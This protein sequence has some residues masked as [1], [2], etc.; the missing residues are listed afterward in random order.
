M[1]TPEPTRGDGH[2]DSGRDDGL[3]AGAGPGGGL[4][5]GPDSGDRRRPGAHLPGRVLALV[6]IAVALGAIGVFT[7]F[8]AFLGSAATASGPTPTDIDFA[9]VLMSAALGFV[10][11][12]ALW[13]AAA[14][15]WKGSRFAVP[16]LLALLAVLLAQSLWGLVSEDLT[17]VSVVGTMASVLA[18]AVTAALALS[19]DVRDFVRPTG[20]GV[21]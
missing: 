1:S 20:G 8:A 6:I 7:G 19:R 18:V 15:L 9:E 17:F 4:G 14:L 11:G 5:E 10:L 2:H 3:Y 21:D 12:S 16:L 13:V